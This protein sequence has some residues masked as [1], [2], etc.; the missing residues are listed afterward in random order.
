MTLH[1]AIQQLLEPAKRLEQAARDAKD[2]Y[3]DVLR[4]VMQ[5]SNDL[6]AL[7]TEMRT[8]EEAAQKRHIELMEALRHG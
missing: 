5:H 3:A 1:D 7:R 2:G 6:S 4:Q 8:N